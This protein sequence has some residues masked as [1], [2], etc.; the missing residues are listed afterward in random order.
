MM[1]SGE[2]PSSPCNFSAPPCCRPRSCCSSASPCL[3]WA[4]GS[5]CPVTWRHPPRSP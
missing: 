2:R 1:A 4:P 3:R 5:G